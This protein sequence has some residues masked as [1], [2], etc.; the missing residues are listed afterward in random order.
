MN[1]P[2]NVTWITVKQWYT[3]MLEKGVT[4][5]CDDP[6]A[7]AVMIASKVEETN[8]EVDM[9][10]TY[11]LARKF[12]LSPE[13]KTFLFKMLQSLLPT[14]E[15]LARVGKV[16]SPACTFCSAPED[17][18]AHLLSCT[19]STAVTSPLL[20]C[21]SDHADNITPQKIVLLNIPTAESME[22][23]VAWLVSTC[24]MMVW[25]DRVAG[26]VARLATCQ[27]ELKAR[28][29]VLKHTRWKHYTLHNSALL[30]EEM[31]NLHFE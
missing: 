19:Q 12:G 23:P 5:T 6:S 24:L 22:L 31:L 30:L 16:Q 21:L 27:A 13:Q 28:L 25:E 7:P 15:R 3:L 10:A 2:L 4:H 8:P 26:R 29:L 20:R 14:R 11:R 18:T 17:N 9:A 1:T